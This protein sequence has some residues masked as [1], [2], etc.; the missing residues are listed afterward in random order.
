MSGGVT[1]NAGH[2]N[3]FIAATDVFPCMVCRK[4]T[5]FMEVHFEGPL[6]PG[7]CETKMWNDYERAL[8]ATPAL[9]GNYQQPWG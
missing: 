5:R 2:L 8:K 7:E 4:E 1:L 3:H 9:P 6:H